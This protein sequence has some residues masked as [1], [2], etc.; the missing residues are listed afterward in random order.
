MKI[1]VVSHTEHY[2]DEKGIVYGWGATV[3]E[4]DAVAERFGEVVHVACLHKTNTIPPSAL[5]YTGKVKFV[6]IPPFGGAGLKNKLKIITSAIS[7][8]RIISRELNL[9]DVFQFRAP[10]SIGL[11][12]IPYLTFFTKKKGWYKYAGNWMQDNPPISYRLQRW[13]LKNLQ[14]RK[15]SINGRW[16]NQLAKCITFEN[17]CLTEEDRKDG[18]NALK[19]KDYSQ[20]MRMCF[21]GRMDNEKGVYD[22]VDAIKNSKCKFAS[23]DFIGDGP[24]LIKLKQ[25]AADNNVAAKF[26]GSLSRMQVFETYRQSHLI[27][28]PSKSEG[29]PKAI[30]EAAN[31]GCIPVV[32]DVSSIG[33]YINETNGFLWNAQ[34]CTFTEYFNSLNIGDATSL[35]TKAL[36]AHE[37]AKSFTYNNYLDKLESEILNG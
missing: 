24:E 2:V 8:L 33:Q 29:F 4:L 28:L 30:A 16:N 21:V 17:P 3:K 27:L 12:I 20:P 1:L 22:I 13:M 7:N 31:F 11:Y 18:F 25:Y 14:S 19:V 10:T 5:P 6:P 9:A 15:I 34:K 32:S 37:M 36:K 35:K 23:I 26:H